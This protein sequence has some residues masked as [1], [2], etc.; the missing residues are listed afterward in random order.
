[1]DGAAGTL[2]SVVPQIPAGSPLVTRPDR[3]TRRWTGY[4]RPWNPKESGDAQE[5]RHPGR[6]ESRVNDSVL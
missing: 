5:D 1:M 6:H 3:P 2:P 4:N